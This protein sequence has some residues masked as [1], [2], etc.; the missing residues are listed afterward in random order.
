MFIHQY[1]RQNVRK[2]VELVTEL[3]SKY[4]SNTNLLLLTENSGEGREHNK[5][6]YSTT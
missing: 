4:D 6:Q 3:S 1:E 5:E 2:I